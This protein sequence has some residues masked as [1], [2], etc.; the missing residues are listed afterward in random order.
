MTS[1]LRDKW[2]REGSGWRHSVLGPLVIYVVTRIVGLALVAWAST[3]Q[4][5]GSS[6]TRD[7]YRYF[8]FAPRTADPGVLGV[9]TNWDGEWYALI[10]TDGYGSPGAY[11]GDDGTYVSTRSWSFPPGF[12]VLIRLLM[13]VF[14][15]DFATTAL[16]VNLIAGA[17]AVL[18]IHRLVAPRV[19]RFGALAV[20]ALT[21]CWV[22]APVLLMAYSEA[23]ALALLAGTLLAIDR[24]RPWVATCLVV[25]L[26]MT[27]LVTPAVGVVA[28]VVYAQLWRTRSGS[29]RRSERVGVV[30]LIVFSFVG[31][32]AWS[33]LSVML[34]ATAADDRATSMTTG[35]GGGW[36]GQFWGIHPLAVLFPTAICAFALRVAWSERHAWGA[37][38][39][40]WIASYAVMLVLLTPLQIGIIRYS[41][42]AFPLSLMIVGKPGGSPRLRALRVVLVCLLGI[43]L[44]AVWIR[45]SIVVDT[46]TGTLVGP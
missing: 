32:F 27:R 10:S 37:T 16:A 26:A 39:S 12:P 40:A 44:Q 38:M 19:G 8:V 14:R 35:W 46:A 24:R 15:T 22:S 4:V 41:L 36:F 28:L 6:L 11:T 25:V 30:A 33:A 2:S 5:A 3:H 9:S 7:P 23:I 31:V 43:T 42:L 1:P 18:L 13:Y 34:G 21:C 45:Y 29:I 17:L 20:V